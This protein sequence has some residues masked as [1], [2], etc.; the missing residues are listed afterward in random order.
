MKN[1]AARLKELRTEQKM[2]QADLAARANITVRTLQHYECGTRVPKNIGIV[3]DLAEALGTK[4]DYLLGQSGS[5]VVAA[6][7][8]SGQK[9]AKELDE[10][11][12]EITAQF[13]GGE[14]SEEA[15]DGVMA[16]LNRAYW[17]AKENN[18]KYAPKTKRTKADS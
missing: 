12:N 10:M 15:M 18:K 17:L 14:L 9:A 2:T 7:E 13:A 16:A 3:T 11:V 1:F 4:P 5:Y 6:A 8:T